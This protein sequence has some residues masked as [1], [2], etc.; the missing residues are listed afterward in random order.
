MSM[1]KPSFEFH[2]EEIAEKCFLCEQN[3][4]NLYIVRQISSM[5][6]IHICEG[7]VMSRGKEY[8]LDNTVPWRVAENGS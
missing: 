8:L 5:K 3:H 6:M 2:K 1:S 7:C 4:R